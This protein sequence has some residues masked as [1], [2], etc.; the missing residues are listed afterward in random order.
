MQVDVEVTTTPPDLERRLA[1]YP[2]QT[3]KVMKKTME[4]SLLHI[5]GEIP[6]Y[7]T[8]PVG[9]D[10]SGRTGTLGRT[11]GVSQSG[12]VVGKAEI[13]T[14]RTIGTTAYEGKI[15]TSLP[16]ADRVIGNQDSPWK[17]YWWTLK[18]VAEKARDGIV[19]LHNVA[20][21]ELARFIDGIG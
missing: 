12:G 8:A 7:P 10:A 13:H 4:A 17:S 18:G 2:R 15:G 6:G 20:A 11:L 14:V 21:E 5:Q 3:R 9:V 16:Y 19:R 1:Q